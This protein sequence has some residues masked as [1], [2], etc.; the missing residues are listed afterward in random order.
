M[1][2]EV[3]FKV[4]KPV[5]LTE[6]MCQ[7]TVVAPQGQEAPEAAAQRAICPLPAAAA[8]AAATPAARPAHMHT[9]TRLCVTCRADQ[10]RRASSA[11]RQ[12]ANPDHGSVKT[13]N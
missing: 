3:I 12:S 5:H 10:T 2:N 13:N 1:L 9:A 4:R 11:H 7:G 8:A 6:D